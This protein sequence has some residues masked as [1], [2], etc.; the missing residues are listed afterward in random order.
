LRGLLR[1]LLRCL[2]RGLWRYRAAVVVALGL[3]RRDLPLTEDIGTAA[4]RLANIK[5]Q[6]RMKRARKSR[7]DALRASIYPL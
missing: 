7:L 6:D 5:E 2:L 4:M 3:P 1:G